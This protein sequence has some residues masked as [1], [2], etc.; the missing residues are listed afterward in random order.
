[1]LFIVALAV[2]CA[3]VK[4]SERIHVMERDHENTPKPD[5]PLSS[6]FHP[7]IVS[8]G[9]TISCVWLVSPASLSPDFLAPVPEPS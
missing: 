1:M 2:L 6:G 4:W 9:N 5:P 7:N 3:L 8:L